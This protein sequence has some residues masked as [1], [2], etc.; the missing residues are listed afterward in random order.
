MKA[1]KN[2]INVYAK[3]AVEE[4]LEEESVYSIDIYQYHIMDV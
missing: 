3:E 1:S 2:I 4:V